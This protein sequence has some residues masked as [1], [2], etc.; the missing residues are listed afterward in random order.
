[1]VEL[2]GVG[3]VDSWRHLREE[4]VG[5]LVGL[6]I[7]VQTSEETKCKRPNACKLL[8]EKRNELKT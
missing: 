5:L 2:H 8:S 4:N 6:S 3:A 1:M 7:F